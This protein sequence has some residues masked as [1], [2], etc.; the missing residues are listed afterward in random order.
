MEWLGPIAYDLLL[1]LFA[2]LSFMPLGIIPCA[3]CCGCDLFTDDFSADNLATNYT[4]VSGS[5]AVASGELDPPA[6]GILLLNTVDPLT[7]DGVRLSIAWNFGGAT[8]KLRLLVDYTSSSN[9]HFVE[10]D[11]TGATSATL[12]LYRRSGGSNTALHAVAANIGS[13]GWST[14]GTVAVCWKDGILEGTYNTTGLTD[15]TTAHGGDDVGIETVS[16]GASARADDLALARTSDGCPQC[17]VSGTCCLCST[18][19]SKYLLVTLAGVTD[20]ADCTDLSLINGTYVV[21]FFS[22]NCVGASGLERECPTTGN[23]YQCN[24]RGIGP[25]TATCLGPES[26]LVYLERQ[27]TISGFDCVAG[28]AYYLT[29]WFSAATTPGHSV[30]FKWSEQIATTA[31]SQ[32]ACATLLDTALDFY[33]SYD[34][35]TGMAA[36]Y[37]SAFASATATIEQI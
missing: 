2:A 9:Y 21:E 28:T 19:A 31:S 11:C 30:S 8:G 35:F 16:V 20:H 7:A 6:T 27:C 23:A 32:I 4:Q 3:S 37:N 33:C 5:W 26:M 18:S 17:A 29:A 34:S 24:W 36:S 10:I 25:G 13:F 15:Q 12:Q 22:G 1:A 14:E